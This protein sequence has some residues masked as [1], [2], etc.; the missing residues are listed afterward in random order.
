LR[1][2]VGESGEG[3][4]ENPDY[5]T[6]YNDA[7]LPHIDIGPYPN[8]HNYG[9]VVFVQ[10]VDHDLYGPVAEVW[11]VNSLNGT[12]RTITGQDIFEDWGDAL[13]P[14]IALQFEDVPYAPHEAYVTCFTQSPANTAT[15][16]P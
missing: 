3:T 13:Y 16:H 4:Y 8:E 7:G 15:Y 2:P 10:V 9:A 6:W 14:S 5:S 12:F 1:N 11:A